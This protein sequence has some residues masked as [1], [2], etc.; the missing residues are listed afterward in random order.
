MQSISFF[1]GQKATLFLEIK[2]SDGYLTDSTTTPVVTRIFRVNSSDG[3]AALDGYFGSDGY[4]NPLLKL[5]EGLYYVKLSLPTGAASLGGYL[6]QVNYTNPIN[7]FP[8]S[9]LYNLY[10][11]APFGNF[12]MATTI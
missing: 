7:S 5:N 11:N 8:A 2:N 12:G 1:P 6:V 3:Y 10:I 4:T 9:K